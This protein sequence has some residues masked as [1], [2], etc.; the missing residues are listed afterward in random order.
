VKVSP[1]V[2]TTAVLKVQ[3]EEFAEP[4][5]VELQFVV[6]VLLLKSVLADPPSPTCVVEDVE[7]AVK[8]PYITSATLLV[9][10][11]RI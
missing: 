3:V 11:N 8:V 9:S 7:P 2:G 5:V 10:Y 4:T 6:V 1:E